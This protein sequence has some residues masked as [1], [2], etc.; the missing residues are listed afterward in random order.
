MDFR[1]KRLTPHAPDP[2]K[3]QAGQAVRAFAHTFG[4]AAPNPAK[5]AGQAGFE[6][7]LLPP[8]PVA[9]RPAVGAGLAQ[10]SRVHARPGASTPSGKNTLRGRA[11][12]R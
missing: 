12:N 4:S 1:I 3:N 2:A 10:A 7:F 5:N 9:L 8:V 11:A 6:F